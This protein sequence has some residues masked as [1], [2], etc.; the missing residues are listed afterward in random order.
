MS[1]TVAIQRAV[2]DQ[3]EIRSAWQYTTAPMAE[4]V[5]QSVTLNI[6]RDLTQR[7]LWVAM[8]NNPGAVDHVDAEWFFSCVVRFYDDN[9]VVAEI[10]LQS[11]NQFRATSPAG[12]LVTMGGLFAENTSSFNQ[13]PVTGGQQPPLVFAMPAAGSQYATNTT[14]ANCLSLRARAQ[15]VELEVVDSLFKATAPGVVGLA[16]LSHYL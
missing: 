11:G 1:S 16:C 14:V 5:L 4:G 15:R 7:F 8:G 9:L 13:Y 6:N 12:F 3:T 2:Q 10:P